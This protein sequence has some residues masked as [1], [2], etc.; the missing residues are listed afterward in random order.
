MLRYK[1]EIAEKNQ[2][3]FRIYTGNN[4][5]RNKSKGFKPI[6]NN[7]WG[8]ERLFCDLTIIEDFAETTNSRSIRKKKWSD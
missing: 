8:A 2:K 6:G 1:G 5:E 7:R 3:N 4:C